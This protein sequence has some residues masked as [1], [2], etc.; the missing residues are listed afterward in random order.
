MLVFALCLCLLAL[1]ERHRRFQRAEID[2]FM[3]WDDDDKGR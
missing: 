3:E 1:L 2:R